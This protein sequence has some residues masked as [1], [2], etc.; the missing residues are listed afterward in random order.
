MRAREFIQ[1][2]KKIAKRHQESSRGLHKVVDSFSSMNDFGSDYTLYRLMMA[3]ACTDGS[4]EPDVDPKSW[5]GMS[6]TNYPY[7][8]ADQ[9]KLIKAYKKLGVKFND[10]NKG[11]LE[12]CEL[13]STYTRSPVA[14]WQKTNEAQIKNEAATSGATSSGNVASGVVSPHLSPG[15]ARGKRSYTGF[16]GKSGTKSPPQLKPLKQT[17]S[18]NALN[19]RGSIF[20]TIRKREKK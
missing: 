7:S 18:D 5:I 3:A 16:P 14:N 6:K 12:S 20:G 13:E 4:Y 2:N 10:I 9:N 17:P 8:Q 11:D 15:P 19:K 1:E